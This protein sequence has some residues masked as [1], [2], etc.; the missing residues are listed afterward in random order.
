MKDLGLFDADKIDGEIFLRYS[1]TDDE[2]LPYGSTK[3]QKIK[4]GVPILQDSK[5]IFA[6][7]GVK[8]SIE[9]S[10]DENTENVLVV[11]WGSSSDD[12]KKIKKVFTDLKDLIC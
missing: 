9:T 6:V 3:P 7:I 4:E 12:K 1:T 2:Y 11:S 10:V 5:K 8:D